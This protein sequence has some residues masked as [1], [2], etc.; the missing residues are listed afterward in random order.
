MIIRERSLA[1]RIPADQL[2]E[3]AIAEFIR[4]RGVTRCPT[5]CVL[6][7]QGSVTPRDREALEAYAEARDRIRRVRAAR[8][9][10][11]VPF[12]DQRPVC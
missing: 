5:A 1:G 6:P 2:A 11:F 4:A 9:N 7:T 12:F 3:A 8:R 10:G